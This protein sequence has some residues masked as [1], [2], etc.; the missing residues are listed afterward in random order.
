M[1]WLATIDS[2]C[3]ETYLIEAGSRSG[4]SDLA[5]VPTTTAGFAANGVPA[6]KYY[7]RVRARNAR[8]EISPPSNEIAIELFGPTV[9]DNGVADICVEPLDSAPVGDRVPL[10]LIHG[11][12]ATAVPGPPDLEMWH[13]CVP[14]RPGCDSGFVD[15]LKSNGSLLTRF[16]PYELT[17]TSNVMA[18]WPMAR[19]LPDL[20]AKVEARDGWPSA[21]PIAIVAH[22]MGGL[23]ARA[24]MLQPLVP[25]SGVART[26]GDRV[27]VLITLGTPH[28][29]SPLSNGGPPQ[30]ASIPDPDVRNAA[31][32]SDWTLVN[33]LGWAPHDQVNRTDLWW[34]SSSAPLIDGQVNLLLAHL[35]AH[36][37]YDDRIVA[38]FGQTVRC[39]ACPYGSLG[40]AASL[41]EQAWGLPSDGAVP[42]SSARFD[43]PANGPGYVRWRAFIGYDH[44]QIARG[45]YGLVDPLFVAIG[46]DLRDSVDLRP[47]GSLTHSVTETTVRLGW[48]RPAGPAL[49]TS[50]R[51]EAGTR[52]GGAELQLPL[53]GTSFISPNTP[54]G[55]YYVRVRA[56][57]PAGV[58]APSNEVVVRVVPPPPPGLPTAP[59]GFTATLQGRA[60]SM[61]WLPPVT[62]QPLTGY[63]L[64]AGAAPGANPIRVP[65]AAGQTALAVPDVPDGTYFVRVRAANSVGLG[66]ASNEVSFTVPAPVCQPLVRLVASDG[67]QPNGASSYPAISSDGRHVAFSSVASNLV[68]GDANSKADVFVHDLQTGTLRLVSR[69]TAGEL[70]NGDSVSPSISV[71]G[72]FVAFASQATNLVGGDSNQQPDIFVHDTL[73]STTQLV[74]RNSTGALAN[75]QG[76]LGIP[77]GSRAPAISANGAFVAFDSDA[78]NLAAGTP[79]GP[80]QVYVHDRATG[81]T[82]LVSRSSSGIPGDARSAGSSIS[83]DGNDVAFTSD[84]R[85]FGATSGINLSMVFVHTRPTGVT[86][87]VSA[88]IPGSSAA[89]D[90][91]SNDAAISADGQFVSFSSSGRNLAPGSF[92]MGSEVLSLAFLHD[93]TT[94]LT[95]LVSPHPGPGVRKAWYAGNVTGNGSFVSFGEAFA[96]QVYR[97]S[98]ITGA[99]V[100]LSTSSSGTAGNVGAQ[101]PRLSMEGDISVFSSESLNLVSGDT[102]AVS[103]IF[104]RRLSCTAGGS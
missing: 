25:A 1:D 48:D 88:R 61:T 53:T 95:T 56:I 82:T 49:V 71:D 103:D 22:S 42:T 66:P 60:V 91:S 40:F 14:L 77:V 62:G 58:S 19:R 4:L 52:P 31:A 34:D 18:V 102:N 70:G 54:P 83:A 67:S 55:I 64:E 85:N 39:D 100:T 63:S 90:G 30:L 43:H 72:R 69:N 28:R 74:S 3:L 84:A 20:L 35:Q 79:N 81:L 78:L 33:A 87:A 29:G 6:G 37:L 98:R 16:K 8:G 36:P 2:F 41:M 50:Y 92:P 99:I 75:Y 59:R 27:P 94:G 51:L 11:I 97:W 104:V 38:Y 47:P 24:L 96:G 73:T 68:P 23:I 15:Y 45:R 80:S 26:F 57:G 44:D 93:R 9:C 89:L 10:L 46:A 101:A 5:S 76:F 12:N 21:G 17:Y 32:S 7:L 65:L 13:S 86:T